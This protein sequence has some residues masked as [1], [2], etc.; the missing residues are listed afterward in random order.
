MLGNKV[1]V[2]CALAAVSALPACQT[3]EGDGDAL[4]EAKG[5]LSVASSFGNAPETV[6]V[7]KAKE[8]Y[9]N[10]NYGL[11]ERY[12]RQAME[13]RS[14]NVE[15]WLGLAASYDRLKRFDHADRAY[16]TVMKMVGPTLIVLNNLGYHYMLKGDFE[17]AERTL[18]KAYEQDPT[19]PFVKNNLAT[20][21]SWKASGG[22]TSG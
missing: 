3:L 5:E 9:R 21:E 12:Y 16:K 19:N 7:A 10:G 1:R 20:L 2:L 14:E 15:A 11:A 18:R 22:R 6:W 13:E 4:A 17:S 8:Q